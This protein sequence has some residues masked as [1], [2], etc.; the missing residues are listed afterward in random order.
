[1]KRLML[2]AIALT[3]LVVTASFGVNRVA[4]AAV[5]ID[6]LDG[7][8]CHS[9]PEPLPSAPGTTQG[10][11]KA[12]ATQT[13]PIGGRARIEAG[14]FKPGEEISVFIFGMFPQRYPQRLMYT[15][16]AGSDGF[17]SA[18]YR[19]SRTPESYTYKNPYLCVRGEATGRLACVPFFVSGSGG[20]S[21]SGGATRTT[22]VYRSEPV[23][24]T[25]EAQGGFGVPVPF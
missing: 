22:P 13:V 12:P 24:T 25:P 20:S 7:T 16:K 4:H 8:R 11:R 3:S 18:G 23:R 1:M 17:V 9:Y 2:A 6:Y 5:C 21:S 10:L 15:A 14:P 19:P